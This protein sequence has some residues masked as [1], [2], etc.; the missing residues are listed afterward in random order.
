MRS[1]FSKVYFLTSKLNKISATY[2]YTKSHDYNN[3]LSDIATSYLYRLGL[4]ESPVDNGNID[5]FDNN[6]IVSN[7]L[8][9]SSSSSYGNDLNVSSS[10]NLTRSIV[11]SLDFKYSNSLSIP[12]TASRTENESF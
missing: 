5:L 7:N 2:T 12:S 4:Q 10:V 11:T 9:G 3:I 8:V 1:I 6:M